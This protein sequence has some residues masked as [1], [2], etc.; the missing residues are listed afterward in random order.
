M[1]TGGMLAVALLLG[2]GPVSAQVT[3]LAVGTVAPDFL[4]PAATQAGVLP[5]KFELSE[6]RG[7][8]VVLAF[9]FKARTSG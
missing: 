3:P 7:R 9:F 2:V 4:L 6:L 8:T 5:R 1:K